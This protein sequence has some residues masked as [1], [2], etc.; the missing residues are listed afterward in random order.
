MFHVRLDRIGVQVGHLFLFVLEFVLHDMNGRNILQKS[1]RA[2]KSWVGGDGT[3]EDQLSRER[4]SK[5]SGDER[6][7]FGFRNIGK[8]ALDEDLSMLHEIQRMREGNLIYILIL[9]L[10]SG[11]TGSSRKNPCPQGF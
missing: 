3:Q 8:T 2:L 11:E 9:V 5:A 1:L 4:G 6:H 7:Q 10:D